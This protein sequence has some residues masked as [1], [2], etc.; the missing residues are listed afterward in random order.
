VTLSDAAL[1]LG[2]AAAVYLPK[3]V[4]LVVVSEAL[5]ARLGAWLRYVAPAILGALVAPSML[6]WSGRLVGLDWHLLGFGVA[7]LVALAT[8]RVVVALACGFATILLT[9]VL[10]GQ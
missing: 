4:P 9:T 5:T 6:T 2:M 1:L 3:A 10:V 7:V 8:R